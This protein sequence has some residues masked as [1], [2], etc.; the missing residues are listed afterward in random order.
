MKPD[1]EIDAIVHQFPRVQP[2]CI[3]RAED[4]R[5]PKKDLEDA[6]KAAGLNG[7]RMASFVAYIIGVAPS[8]LHGWRNPDA[9][10]RLPTERAVE[11]VKDW[12]RLQRN[13]EQL[14]KVVGAR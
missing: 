1:A 3:Y 7:H 8:T 6:I 4:E 12:A 11:R 14:R 5:V 9:Q 2:K 10:D 13:P